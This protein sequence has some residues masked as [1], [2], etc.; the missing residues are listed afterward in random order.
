MT[1]RLGLLT[2]S[3]VTAYQRC[4]R[5]HHL[6]YR[7]G[8]RPVHTPDALRFGT[9]VHLGLEAWWRAPA[10]ARLPAALAAVQGRAE[11]IYEQV[12]LDLMLE[13][14]DA[15]WADER[16]EVLGVE[17]EWSAPLVNPRT[18]APSKT[19][20]L[21]GKFDALV[22]DESG[23][24]FVVEHKSTST[25]LDP[26]GFYWERLGGDSQ[27]SIYWLGARALGYEPAGVLYDVLRKHGVPKRATPPEQRKYTKA[28]K[29]E[30]S[31]LYAG[32]RERDETVEEYDARLR[33]EVAEA[34]DRFYGRCNLVR[35][36][37]EE[38][39][40]LE[41]LWALAEQLRDD[42][43][44]ARAPR[45]P[46]ACFHHNRWCDFRSVCFGPEQLDNPLLFRRADKPHEELS[47]PETTPAAPAEE[48]A[49]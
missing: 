27:V 13:G 8:Y 40:A 32:Q 15:R 19:R 37:H 31:R 49:A 29:T 36:E 30:P 10:G 39:A 3:E 47:L 24:V 5:L 25:D 33:G 18:G 28:T 14:Y 21:A 9:L 11:D 12:R 1:R 17:V 20:L 4:P 44:L 45:A 42:V 16:H 43:R 41:D 2:A 23:Q 26:G 6:S 34:P 35:H 22:R 48:H 46:A 7:L 38:R